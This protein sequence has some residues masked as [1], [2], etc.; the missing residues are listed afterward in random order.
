M[1]NKIQYYISKALKYIQIPSIKESI[2]HPKAYIGPQSN[3]IN[4]TIGRYSYCGLNCTIV[5]A[6][7]G[8]FT[9]IS[10]NVTIGGGNHPLDNVS[11]SPAFYINNDYIPKIAKTNIRLVFIFITSI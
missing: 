8:Q 11:T 5:N 6:E 10:D 3:I 7:I 9:S 4:S 2:I 1:L